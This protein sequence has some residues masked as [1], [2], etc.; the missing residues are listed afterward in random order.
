[1]ADYEVVER[2]SPGLVVVRRW[3]AGRASQSVWDQVKVRKPHRCALTQR[4]LPAGS[5]MYRPV[6]NQTYRYER[7]GAAGIDGCPDGGK[8]HHRCAVGC[9]RVENCGPLS[10]AQF[11]DD[12]WPE[13]IVKSHSHNDGRF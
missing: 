6:G 11:P 1:M 8:C 12:A 7:L 5:L 3:E 10:A 9:W 4:E 2:L 13:E